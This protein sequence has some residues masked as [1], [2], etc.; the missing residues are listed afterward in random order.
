MVKGAAQSAPGSF[1]GFGLG[2]QAAGAI[3][4]MTSNPI[5]VESVRTLPMFS[6][7]TVEGLKQAEEMGIN[8]NEEVFLWSIFRVN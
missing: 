7:A 5:I 3:S 4:M 2:G 8:W 1:I 6:T